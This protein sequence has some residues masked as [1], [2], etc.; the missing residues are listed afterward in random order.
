[1]STHQK[2][3]FKWTATTVTGTATSYLTAC[4]HVIPTNSAASVKADVQMYA[5]DGSGSA[6]YSLTAQVQNV[7]GTLTV[8]AGTTLLSATIGTGTETSA[9]TIDSSGTS[10]RLGVNTATALTFSVMGISTLVLTHTP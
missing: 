8:A 3:I 5:T 7:G 1:M 6:G 2:D 10:L 4:A 9:P